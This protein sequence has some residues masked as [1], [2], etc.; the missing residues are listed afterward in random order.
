MINTNIILKIM[1]KNKNKMLNASFQLQ[2]NE[3][4]KHQ[5]ILSVS[6]E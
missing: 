2:D 4:H 5:I 1:S 6:I 3:H